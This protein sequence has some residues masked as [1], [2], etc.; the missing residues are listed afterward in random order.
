MTPFDLDAPAPTHTI[1]S[2]P[3]QA[4]PN[5]SGFPMEPLFPKM[6]QVFPPLSEARTTPNAPQTRKVLGSEGS[7]V[8]ARNDSAKDK[9]T[10]VD[11]VQGRVA[12]V[13]LYEIAG[14]FPAATNTPLL[15]ANPPIT[16]LL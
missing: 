16:A 3:L 15:H 7:G 1:C 14:T 8:T 10:I 11:A 12:G 5:R 13:L 9:L 2:L 6:V 4:M